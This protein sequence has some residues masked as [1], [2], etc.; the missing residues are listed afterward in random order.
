MSGITYNGSDKVFGH[1]YKVSDDEN[2]ILEA[3]NLGILAVNP[4]FDIE[5]YTSDEKM[6]N[7]SDGTLRLQQE[8][9]K[10]IS[11]FYTIELDKKIALKKGSYYSVVIKPK[12]LL[13]IMVSASTNPARG[14]FGL[15]SDYNEV[16]VGQAFQATLNGSKYIWSDLTSDRNSTFRYDEKLWGVSYTLRGFANKARVIT[17]DSNGGVGTMED[18]YIR[19]ASESYINKNQ[20]TKDDYIF[21]GWEDDDNNFFFFF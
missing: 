14:P 5:I 20:F 8:V 9:S 11:G 1:V 3:I 15:S 18:Q 4:L 6:E 10:E 19:Y 16:E 2:Q 21:I 12:S 13:V 7:C 17:F